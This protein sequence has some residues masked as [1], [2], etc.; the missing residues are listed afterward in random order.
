MTRRTHKPF[1]LRLRIAGPVA[2]LFL[3]G[4][5]ALYIAAFAYGRTAADRSYDR[6]LAGAARSIAETL[7]ATA[8]G[9]D[10]DI[11]YSA[12]EL[13]SAAP[14]DRVF[15]R[16][17]ETSGRTVTGYG[18]LPS[19]PIKPRPSIYRPD[20]TFFTADYL[21]EPV[22]FVV[23]GR[24]IATINDPLELRSVWVQVGQTR[25]AHQALVR[26]LV[27][28]SLL[29]IA[30][31]TVI[32]LLIAWFG[33]GKGLRPLRTISDELAARGPTDLDEIKAPVPREVAPLV[34]AIDGFMARLRVNID[35]LRSFVGEAAHQLRTPLAALRAQA[36]VA[37]RTNAEELG[38]SLAAV[39]RNA[40]KLTRLVNQMLSDATVS[41]R[42][43]VR[44]R[45][46]FD[47]ADVLREIV[48]EATAYTDEVV[49]TL[50]LGVA[51]APIVGDPLMTAEARRNI[52]DYAQAHGDGAIEI[53][54]TAIARTYQID[55]ADRGPG[56]PDARKPAV[57]ERFVRGSGKGAGAGLG[58]AIAS[59]A[60]ASQGGTIQLLDRPGGGLVVRLAF[61]MEQV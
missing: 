40:A 36:Q 2:A 24:Q 11:P 43:D 60:I 34:S 47:L 30:A 23:V 13:L 32:A 4:M 9:F 18:D 46:A 50:D 25:R 29:P 12:F 33:V 28:R 45:E 52:L 7:V 58:L 41:Q 51:A 16:V 61:P 55:F 59:Q 54:L 27:I 17:F 15:Y 42:S 6:L 1:S 10:V 57:F 19:S 5:I 56:I 38:R 53:A 44:H 35:T 3:V 21:G 49:C 31:M 22:R 20:A 37:D 26:E 8:D 39:E 14:D 48:H